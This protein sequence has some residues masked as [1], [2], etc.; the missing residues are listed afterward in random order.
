VTDADSN[1]SESV[2]LNGSG[3]SDIDG[4]I[5]NYRWNDGTTI[6]AQGAS[7]TAIITLPVGTKTITL[8]VTDNSGFTS[9]DTV[10]IKVNR[11]PTADAGA[12]FTVIDY[13]FSGTEAFTL[14][15]SA[16]FDLD[17]TI[18][19]YK[20]VTGSTV[21]YEGP[22]PTATFTD[23][24]GT[25]PI[26]L[27][28]TDNNG[29]ESTDVVNVTIDSPPPPPQ[30]AWQTDNCIADYNNDGSIDGDDVILF[31]GDWD[32]A[33]VCSDVDGSGGVDGDDVIQFFNVWDSAGVG[34]PGC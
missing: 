33:A 10:Q 31:F 22:L 24:L 29:A 18:V 9:T 23:Q 6:L 5:T 1:G 32:A 26:T 27:T 4:T 28:V 17:G 12:D 3:S 20:W 2:T 14:D 11:K 7:P 15:G 13:D 19:Q 21:I 8:T 25:W 30:C 16:S 34:I